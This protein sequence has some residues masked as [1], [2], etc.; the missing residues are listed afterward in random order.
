MSVITMKVTANSKP[1][2]CSHDEHNETKPVGN[3]TQG[4]EARPQESA[5]RDSRKTHPSQN[6]E[7]PNEIRSHDTPVVPPMKRERTQRGAP[8]F[9]PPLARRTKVS[10]LRLTI[11][12]LNRIQGVWASLGWRSPAKPPRPHLPL[13]FSVSAFRILVPAY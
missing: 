9:L 7:T 4:C 12:R 11:S 8:H 1:R 3:G 2:N 5:T 6:H 13:H 10:T